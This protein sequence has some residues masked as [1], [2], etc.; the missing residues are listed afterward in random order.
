MKLKPGAVGVVVPARRVPVALQDKVKAELQGMEAQGV[1]AKVTEPTEWSS[2][3]VTVLKKDKQHVVEGG[4]ESPEEFCTGVGESRMTLMAHS[5]G[6]HLGVLSHLLD[7]GAERQVGR[8]PE[9][10]W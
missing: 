7:Q 10:H 1:I 3:M 9:M 8:A 5:L 2:H 4:H 6:E